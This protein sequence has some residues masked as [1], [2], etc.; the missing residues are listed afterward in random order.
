MA[1]PALTQE[2]QLQSE[3]ANTCIRCQ[4]TKALSAKWAG[5]FSNKKETLAQSR[6]RHYASSLRL[7]QTRSKS[8][9]ELI[10]SRWVS[11]VGDHTQQFSEVH[12]IPIIPD[13]DLLIVLMKQDCAEN[14]SREINTMTNISLYQQMEILL[15]SLLPDEFPF[16]TYPPN[17]I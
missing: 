2:H 3:L 13:S 4:V 16:F 12:F 1:A 11:D 5:A 9:L 8:R 15:C 6:R 17:Y 7:N 10:S 14:I